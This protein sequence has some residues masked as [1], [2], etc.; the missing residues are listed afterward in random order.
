MGASYLRWVLKELYNMDIAWRVVRHHK[1][2]SKR[3]KNMIHDIRLKSF[4][5]ATAY[6]SL[7]INLTRL[8]TMLRLF[9]LRQKMGGLIKYGESQYKKKYGYSRSDVST[10]GPP[11]KVLWYLPIIPMLKR[12]FANSNDAKNLR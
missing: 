4:Q 3:R 8:S 12:L 7:C 10:K 1:C 11:T 2:V 5:R 9:N 6:D